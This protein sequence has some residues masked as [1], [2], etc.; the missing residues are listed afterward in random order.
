MIQMDGR[1]KTILD[2]LAREQFDEALADRVLAAF[3]ATYGGRWTDITKDLA[4]ASDDEA[5]AVFA[6][7]LWSFC[8]EVMA[9]HEVNRAAKDAGEAKRAEVDAAIGVVVPVGPAV[10]P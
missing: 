9:G 2:Q 8:A 1:T 5:N 7:Q 6:A 4:K 3:L 10:K